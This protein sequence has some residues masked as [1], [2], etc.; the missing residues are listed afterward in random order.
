MENTTSFLSKQAGDKFRLKNNLVKNQEKLN[1][2]D[3]GLEY[4]VTPLLDD[5]QLAGGNGV[6]PHVRIHGRG[7]NHRPEF[8]FMDI[9]CVWGAPGINLQP[10]LWTNY[11]T[12]LP[13]SNS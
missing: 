11:T 1:L 4:G 9:L 2:A 6:V 3:L 8:N 13:R 12:L 10:V 7:H 5:V